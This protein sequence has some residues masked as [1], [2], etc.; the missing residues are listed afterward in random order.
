MTQPSPSPI[1]PRPRRQ[2]TTSRSVRVG[3]RLSR[4]LITAGGVGTILAVSLI[5]VFLIYVVAPL[6]QGAT[7]EPLTM[8]G[9]PLSGIEP[10]RLEVDDYRVLGLA[11]ERD[12]T[13]VLWR[14]DTG[15][16]LD[17]RKLFSQSALTAWSFPIQGD[18]AAFGFADG[19]VRFGRIGF[20][21]RFF[22]EE[23]EPEALRTLDI[24]HV[25][26][27]EKGVAQRTPA[28]QL[29]TQELR[30][31]L[32]EP[33]AVAEQDAVVLVDHANT[34]T[35][36]VFA[37]LTNSGR[38]ALHTARQKE[39]LLTGEKT[40]KLSSALLPY[41]SREGDAPSFL[42]VSGVGDTVYV[43]WEDG[44]LVRFDAR[45]RDE[46]RVAEDIDLLP[47]EGAR[48]TRLEPQLGRTTLLAAD[49]GGTVT[50][51]FPATPTE[52]QGPAQTSDGRRLDAAQHLHGPDSPVTALV[53]SARRHMV[54]V[55]YENGDTRLFYVLGENR[56]QGV[57]VDD[58][59]IRALTI[60]PKDD[61]LFAMSDGGLH[62]WALDVKHP[63]ATF[64]TLFTKIRYEGSSKPEHVWQSAGG[65]DDFQPKLGLVP[66]IFGTLKATFF[67]MLFG[68]PLALLAAL[69]T[70]EFLAPRLRT[71]I[72]STIEIMA[73]LPSVVLGFI[74]A[75]VIAPFVQQVVPSVLA[76]FIAVPFCFLLGAYLWQLLPQDLILRWAG[77]QR[78]ATII[79]ALPLGVALAWVLGPLLEDAVFAGDIHLW[80][81][82]QIGSGAGAWAF[83]LLPVVALVA[84]FVM[85][86]FVLPAL[87]QRTD[88][89]SREQC[90]TFDLFRFLATTGLVVG[91]AW[92]LGVLLT[93]AGLDPRG[94]IVDT[95]DKNN[96]L[97]VGFV[98]GFAIIPIIYT[99][100]EDALSS[101][102]GHL[103]EASLGAGAT[104]WQTATR[105]IVP[106]AMSG[107]FSAV[108]IG[109][110]RA[111]GET[112][113]VLMAAG[114][115]PI[116]EWNVFNGF[117]TLSANIAT[118]MPEAVRDSTHYRTL[119]LAALTLFAMTFVLNTIAEVVRQR[120]RRRAYQL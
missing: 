110:G 57:S 32:E 51:W 74:A 79:L 16:V 36:R 112:M 8:Q 7:V 45:N 24:G 99:L 21:T 23:E 105:I 60:A 86:R 20:R 94:S 71:S 27:H 72:K 41:E 33:V 87:R 84:L 1:A 29:R 64:E 116:M 77:W 28:G 17:R 49:D 83:F 30:V 59:A 4:I 6:F 10:V 68:V 90:A 11:L 52:E 37:A 43:A 9:A 54:A 35:G 111:V 62:G 98:M 100:A 47:A 18:E 63:E 101:V 56:I 67:S 46:P 55:G 53:S 104:R 80:L 69:Y 82:G 34:T 22:S 42:S 120:F 15:E 58:G 106:T 44:R 39:N 25:A 89:W 76:L 78:L 40:T 119:F 107:L 118:E 113:I 26:I 117:R 66:L 92:L 108:M 70:S 50:A 65:T 38:L 75:L 73:S 95:Y 48:L 97:V 109:L 91:L 102:P 114:N 115:S 61:G 103:R 3:E 5:M 14:L 85:A 13:L 12:G 81:D 88:G 19:T 2:R 93:K 96:A 31:E